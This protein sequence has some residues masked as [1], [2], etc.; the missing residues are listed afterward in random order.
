MAASS[1]GVVMPELSFSSMS[2]DSDSSHRLRSPDNRA[3][4]CPARRLSA[5][6]CVAKLLIAKQQ[7]SLKR[8]FCVPV[9][10]FWEVFEG[11]LFVDNV[12]E[13]LG[14]FVVD[15][16]ELPPICVEWKLNV[17]NPSWVLISHTIA[18]KCASIWQDKLVS[19]WLTDNNLE[20]KAT[21]SYSSRGKSEYVYIKPGNRVLQ[22]TFILM[23]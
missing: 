14:T 3:G 19:Q 7:A 10:L 22:L 2:L 9:P 21:D 23:V 20:K 8:M 16:G 1:A 4:K 17:L 12:P 11:I 13:P 6:G 18:L 15:W 5:E